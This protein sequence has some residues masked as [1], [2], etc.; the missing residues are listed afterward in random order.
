MSVRAGGCISAPPLIWPSTNQLAAS[1]VW[2]VCVCVRGCVIAA[3]PQDYFVSTQPAHCQPQVKWHHS[4]RLA[5]RLLWALTTAYNT[6]WRAWARAPPPCHG[7]ARWYI[8]LW[9]ETAALGLH[10]G[11]ATGLRLEGKL[12]CAVG[13]AALERKHPTIPCMVRHEYVITSVS[14]N[15]MTQ[16]FI[17]SDR[18]PTHFSALYFAFR[19]HKVLL[20]LLKW[21]RCWFLFIFAKKKN[22]Y[23]V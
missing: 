17:Q 15:G 18:F 1:L 21:P 11:L 12:E 10:S 23:K 6:L 2:M 19:C 3:R 20:T 9:W 16:L 14:I 22:L 5:G 13:N 4:S 8:W 7:N